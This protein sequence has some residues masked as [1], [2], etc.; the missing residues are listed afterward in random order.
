MATMKM[1]CAVGTGS[2]ATSD[3]SVMEWSFTSAH[4]ELSPQSYFAVPCMGYSTLKITQTTNYSDTYRQMEIYDGCVLSTATLV[5]TVCN[6]KN[7]EYSV[8][9][10]SCDYIIIKRKSLQAG[11]EVHGTYQLCL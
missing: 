5:D 4:A 1:P 6:N 7:Q 3:T 10:S 9:I 8:D 2:G 11:T